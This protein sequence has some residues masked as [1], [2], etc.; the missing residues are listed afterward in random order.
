MRVATGSEASSIC[1]FITGGPLT[2]PCAG[3]TSEG[4]TLRL[5]L[6]AAAVVHIYMYIHIC[7]YG[8]TVCVC[9]FVCVCVCVSVCLCVVLLSDKG[10]VSRVGRVG[11]CCLLQWDLV[12]R[13]GGSGHNRLILDSFSQPRQTD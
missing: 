1:M 13:A 4:S 10:C 7:I 8:Y 3:G 5:I 2:K 11:G 6:S 9:V 12:Q